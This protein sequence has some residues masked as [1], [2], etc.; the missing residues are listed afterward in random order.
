LEFEKSTEK[1]HL[2]KKVLDKSI[3]HKYEWII[4]LILIYN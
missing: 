3:K 4:I 1:Q 2:K